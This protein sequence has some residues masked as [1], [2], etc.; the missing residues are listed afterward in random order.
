MPVS[1]IRRACATLRAM[2]TR[3][4]GRTGLDLSVLTFGCGAVG[5]LMT[6]GAP[7]DQER[8]VARALEAGVNHFDTAPSY[9]DG[10]S[11]QNVG[12]VFAALKPDV[13]LSTKVRIPTERPDVGA[14]IAASLEASLK[15]LR[16]DHVDLFQLHNTIA[17]R[18]NGATMSVEEVLG[19]VGPALNRARE[20]GKTLF[21]GF[22]AIGE[23]EA[24]LKLIASGAFD[25][26][27]VPYNALNPSAGETIAA[28]YPA[29]DYGRILDHAAGKGVGTIGI[30]ALAG[31]ALSGSVARNPL[32][33]QEVEP[34]GSGADYANDA[35]RGPRPGAKGGGGHAA[36]PHPRGV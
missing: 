22:T 20:Q 23:T 25:S 16:R 3:K 28:A 24:L 15:R 6:R 34:I 30:R 21:V 10:A 7:G 5:G 14:I 9:G 32:G 18:A 13:V 4:F 31:G 36:G 33:L 27:Q 26:A 8:A 35:A 2:Q 12:R 19:R 11:E 17:A 29:Q 1:R